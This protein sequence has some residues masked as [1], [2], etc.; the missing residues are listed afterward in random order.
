MRDSA[1]RI[2]AMAGVRAARQQPPRARYV[3]QRA[4]GIQVSR[5]RGA[6]GSAR[7]MRIRRDPMSA[8]FRLAEAEDP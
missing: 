8:S 3:A 5:V 7:K 1:R 2:E 4:G 6:V